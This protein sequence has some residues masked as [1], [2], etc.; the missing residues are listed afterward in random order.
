M[1]AA[2]TVAGAAIT[3]ASSA[4]AWCLW[5][6]DSGVGA[7][8]A[9]PPALMTGTAQPYGAYYGYGPAY[10]YA[11]GHA[12]S[13]PSPGCFWRNQTVLGW[14]YLA[15]S[16]GADLLLRSDQAKRSHLALTPT[17]SAL[18]A[19]PTRRRVGGMSPRFTRSTRSIHPE[20]LLI[21]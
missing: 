11:P 2:A 12:Y 21:R 4:K 3:G 7:P 16:A 18:F 13:G 14:Q 5:G 20:R 8:A 9:G 1:A 17:R 19:T 6:C 10:F 15:R